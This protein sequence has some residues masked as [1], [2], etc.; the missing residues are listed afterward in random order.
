ME[1]GRASSLE[2]RS[3]GRPAAGRPCTA[4]L[5]VGG[6]ERPPL[7]G[8]RRG[9]AGSRL[10]RDAVDEQCADA[11]RHSFATHLLENGTNIRYIQ[12]LLGHKS[13]QSTLVYLKVTPQSVSSVQSPL[14][15]LTL[16]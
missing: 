14:D 3:A 4:R 8:R 10:V 5:L 6:S 11:L 2:W 12:E 15:Q 1:A 9:G 13:I 16:R 7:P